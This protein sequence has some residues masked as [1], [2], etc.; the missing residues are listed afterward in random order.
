[1]A[2]GG[3]SRKDILKLCGTVY[4]KQQVRLTGGE[5]AQLIQAK[6]RDKAVELAKQAALRN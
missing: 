1:M 2:K 3:W 5:M 6:G 4:N